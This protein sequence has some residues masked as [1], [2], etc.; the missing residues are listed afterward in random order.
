[1]GFD[2]DTLLVLADAI[3]SAVMA[4]LR[5]PLSTKVVVTGRSLNC[6]TE[7]EIKF[8]PVTLRSKPAPGLHQT[9]KTRQSQDGILGW[10]RWSR[11]TTAVTVAAGDKNRHQPQA[12]KC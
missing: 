5:W 10:R 2:T 6:T 11:R 8:E 3:S 1:M 4:A 7:P 9:A 12:D